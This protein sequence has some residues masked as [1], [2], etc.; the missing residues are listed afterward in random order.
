MLE[1]SLD[2]VV[3]VVA[4]A[5]RVTVTI[6]TMGASSGATLPTENVWMLTTGRKVV[7]E[8]W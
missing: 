8:T 4:V 7:R 2:A 5:V 3:V 6:G 1:L